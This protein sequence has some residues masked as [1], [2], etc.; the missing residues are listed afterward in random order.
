MANKKASKKSGKAGTANAALENS[1]LVAFTPASL[2]A[3]L[4]VLRTITV[5][6]LVMKTAGMGVA[7]LIQSALRVSTVVTKTADGKPQEPATICNVT[8]VETGEQ[9]I[10]LVPKVVASNLERDYPDEGY[11]GKKFWIVNKGKRTPSQRY[12]DFE[13]HEIE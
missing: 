13:I 11:V 1:P 5:P 6:S 3:G 4:K 7:M 10:F 12:N 8:N 2:P 9:F